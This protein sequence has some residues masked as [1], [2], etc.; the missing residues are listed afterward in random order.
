MGAITKWVQ[1]LRDRRAKRRGDQPGESA[2][3]ARKRQEAKAR[4]LEHERLDNKLPR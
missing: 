1:G 2:E 3:R 4:R